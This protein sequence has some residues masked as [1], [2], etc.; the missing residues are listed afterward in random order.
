MYLSLVNLPPGSNLYWL[1]TA[2]LF[3]F[4]GYAVWL[5]NLHFKVR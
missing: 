5:I 3:L 2:I 4:C 1:V